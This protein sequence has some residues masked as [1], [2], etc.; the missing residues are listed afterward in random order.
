MTEQEEEY[1]H[2][3][4]CIRQLN[5]V[6]TILNRIKGERDSPLVEPAFRFALVAYATSYNRSDGPV[7]KGRDARQLDASLVPAEFRELHKRILQARKQIHA[8]SDLTI[9]DAQLSINE[10]Q[11]RRYV[12]IAKNI[13]HGMEEF[14]NLESIISL[15]EGTLDKMYAKREGLERALKA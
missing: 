11:G 7:R 1:I 9:M 4:E 2:F 15:I 6:W 3:A 14:E 5:Y 8:H 12:S 13:T 10:T